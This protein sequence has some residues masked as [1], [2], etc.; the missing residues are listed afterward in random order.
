MQTVAVEHSVLVGAGWRGVE[1]GR[2]DGRRRGRALGWV[3]SVVGEVGHWMILAP[4]TQKLNPIF[5]LVSGPVC[6]EPQKAT[7]LLAD[8]EPLLLHKNHPGMALAPS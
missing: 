7:H 8:G 2:G 4:R 1:G 3:F 5:H 6:N